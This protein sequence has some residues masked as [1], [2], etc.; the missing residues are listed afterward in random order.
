MADDIEADKSLRLH[1]EQLAVTR[2]TVA[3][4][5]VQAR[6]VTTQRDQIIDETLSHQ[7]VEVTRVPIGR[8]VE[9][10]PEIRHEGDVMILPVV[11]EEL[12]VQR[13]LV[14]KEEVHLRRVVTT[15]VHHEA[16]A[17]REQD[18]VITRL[19]ADPGQDG[20]HPDVVSTSSRTG[21]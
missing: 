8:V 3:R 10:A 2:R 11:E 1:A 4:G 19:D 18:V 20:I 9:R 6:T 13:R 5:V 16:V 17:L 14:L 15:S 7:R 12:I 21:T